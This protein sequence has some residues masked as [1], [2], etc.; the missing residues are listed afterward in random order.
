MHVQTKDPKPDQKGPAKDRWTVLEVLR[1]TTGRFQERALATPRLDAE[2]LIAAALGLPRVQLY[3]QFERPLEV[4]ELAVI[5]E[6]VRRRQAGESV[7]YVV[8]HK[9]FFGL[10]F[11]VDSRVL[12]PRPDTETLVDEALARWRARGTA[13]TVAPEQ[14]SVTALASESASASASTSTSILE[15]SSLPSPEPARIADVGTGSGAIVIALGRQLPD[16]ALFAVDISEPALEVARANAARH[17]VAVTFVAGDLTAPL[18]SLG[19]FD[20]IVSNP[21][22]VPS[23][24]IAQL[25]PEVRSEPA[26]ALDGGADGLD[27]VRRIVTAAPSLL[28]PG[29]A[30]AIEIGAGQAEPT[31]ALFYAAG[32]T[33]VRLRRDL[34]SVDRVVSGVK[35]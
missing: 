22:Y 9:E 2:V 6:H 17:A 15:T 32:F 21:P 1:W 27:L 30:L 34:G 7:A 5:R 26:L 23:A 35:P 31:V 12:V 16:A 11:A 4:A 25:A 24:D 33:D 13:P 29:G 8:G 20:V 10:E 3:V 18:A 14:P 28:A 19:P